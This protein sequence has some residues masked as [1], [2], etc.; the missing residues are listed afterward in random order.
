METAGGLGR[1]HDLR[2]RPGRGS[3]HRLGVAR[4]QRPPQPE[5]R[6]QAP[7]AA[8]GH[9]ARLRARQ[10]RPGALGPAQ[11]SRR[12]GHAAAAVGGLADSRPGAARR[13]GLRVGHRRAAR[14]RRV[15]R[16]D[17][18]AAVPRHAQP[19]RG[20]GRAAPRVRPAAALGG[21]SP[22][23]RRA[24]GCSR[25]RASGRADPAR[26]R[27]RAGQIDQISRQVPIVTLAGIPS[28][29][30][31][32]WAATTWRACAPWR[33]TCSTT[34]GTH[35]RLPHRVQRQP[36]QPG[37]AADPG[38]GGRRRA[39]CASPA[40][41]GG[42]TTTRRAR[43]WSRADACVGVPCP[44]HRLRDDQTAL[45]VMQA[46]RRSGVEVPG[47]V[48]V[49]GFDDVPMAR[50]VHPLLTTVRQPIGDLGEHRLRGAVLHDRPRGPRR[51]GHLVAH[52][53]D[54]PGE[55]WLPGRLRPARRSHRPV[56]VRQLRSWFT[57]GRG[58][59]GGAG[60]RTGAARRCCVA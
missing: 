2:R 40:R 50:H 12:R 7:G 36:G 45:G 37:A 4:A 38:G 9:R 8:G 23:T 18:V 35:A 5:P 22:T 29:T 1:A 58:R 57:K 20:A 53:A 48:A 16:R 41:S 19:G 56:K 21:T 25:S 59:G 28:P 43:R 51:T 54:V 39:R 15:R 27:P 13:G 42:A 49:T 26:R 60:S 34:T 11:G 30:R 31:R 3:V 47:T 6:D 52:P 24:A 17:R 44:G 10:R 55:L 32:T 33:G 14:L 46:L